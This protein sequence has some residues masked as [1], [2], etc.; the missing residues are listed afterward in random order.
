M[1]DFTD[2]YRLVRAAEA[3]AD[4][5]AARAAAAADFDWGSAAVGRASGS[6]A[7]SP[8]VLAELRGIHA[9]L[10]DALRVVPS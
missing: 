2:W 9:Q 10:S 7:A 5:A 1:P 6:L 4:P 3:E 8:Q